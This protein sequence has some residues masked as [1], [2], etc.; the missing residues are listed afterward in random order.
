MIDSTNRRGFTLTELIVVLAIISITATIGIPSLQDVVAGT[1]I[2]NNVMELRDGITYTRTSA[3]SRSAHTILCP[4]NENTGCHSD[5]SKSISIFVDRNHDETPDGNELLRV[6][7]PSDISITVIP[8]P[9]G[10]RYFRFG[11]TGMISGQAG[12]FVVCMNTA[13]A[14]RSMAYIAVNFGGRPR[15]EWDDDG[16]RHIELSSGKTVSCPE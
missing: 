11:P 1:K 2:R 3:I 5:W 15:V 10:K 6:L 16:D 9:T 4:W 12:S 8:R 7:T 13:S 14:S